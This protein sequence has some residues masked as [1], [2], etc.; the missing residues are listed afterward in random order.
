MTKT[1]MG[2]RAKL[3]GG[4]AVVLIITGIVAFIGYTQLSAASTRQTS[5]YEKNL[6]GVLYAAETNI[7][8]I[9]SAREEKRAFLTAA[10]DARNKLIVQS[11]AEM[12]DAAKSGKLYEQTYINDSDRVQWE[13][14]MAGVRG[15]STTR[16]QV[17]QLL[18]K[19]QDAEAKATAAGMSD[20]I[21][22]MNDSLDEAATLNAAAA[23]DSKDAGAAAAGFAEWLLLASTAIAV[24][25]GLGIGFWLARDISQRATSILSRLQ[26]LQEHCLT[27]LRAGMV[28]LAGGNLTV[29]VTPVTQK[30][31]ASNS[32]EIGQAVDQTNKIIDGMVA[33]IAAYNESRVSLSA[34]MSEVRN[35]ATALDGQRRELD[36]LSSDASQAT[37]AVASGSD[38]VSRASTEV[39]RAITQVA[40]GASQQASSVQEVNRSIEQL[41]A[42]A[43][44]VATGAQQQAREVE[45]IAGVSDAVARSAQEMAN[46]AQQAAD[47]ARTN[48]QSAEEGAAAVEKT[49]SGIHSIQQALEAASAEVATLGSRSAEIG[50]IVSVIQ[51]IAAQTNLLALNA[52]IEAARAG[53]QGRGFAVVADE[54]RQLAE[55]VANATKEIG[56]L[57]TGV[58][59]DVTSTVRA[60]EQGTTEM[61]AGTSAAGEAS[62]SL[63][64]ILS[65]SREVAAQIAQISQ[66]ATQV[67]DQGEEM[68][69]RI[70]GVR[71]IVEQNSA[72]A[73]EMQATAA[74]VG[75]SITT[76][77]SIA[78]ENSA[79]TEEVSAATEEVSASA[80]EM[81][82]SATMLRGQ[83]EQVTA[84]AGDLGRMSA[85]LSEQVATFKLVDEGNGQE[86]GRSSGAPA[87]VADY[88]RRA[89]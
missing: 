29:G 16:E 27:D 59:N 18:E 23:K 46:Q 2:I 38:Q 73:E 17:L 76:V 39:A 82:A 30:I 58:Q 34:T 45:A 26:S 87:S 80:E 78:E 50:N 69:R 72:A 83:M 85:Q 28:A 68:A 19:G 56:V 33:T 47:G 40:E 4:F 67:Q 74:S 48:A 25:I 52:A 61:A 43:T 21:D 10:G 1:G 24:A 66:T 84:A 14:V 32:D 53:D 44:Q 79:A 6:L 70:A 55:R 81:T 37:D 64:L 20:A 60:M 5:A 75:D 13:S 57:I 65:A 15:V 9:S 22:K 86:S 8:M 54:V 49:T 12:Q 3:L 77:A 62:E 11:R 51:D 35:A 42:A 7:G 88:R 71:D 36:T 41:S 63:K 31:P 89:A